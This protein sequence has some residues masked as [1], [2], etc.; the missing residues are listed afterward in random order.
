MD[1]IKKPQVTGAEKDLEKAGMDGLIN[2]L[3]RNEDPHI[4]RY[5]AYLLGKS[6]DA[7][8]VP[9]LIAALSDREKGVREQA[10]LALSELGRSAIEPLKKAMN[11]PKWETRYRAVEALG[12]IAD[13]Q[14][15]SPLINALKDERDH[16]RYMAAKGLRDMQD[17]QAIDPLIALLKDEN[18][19]VRMMAA[20]GLG[21]LGGNKVRAELEQALRS[22]QNDRVKAAIAEAMK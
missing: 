9:V 11:D 3:Q 8:T 6:G 10:A 13:Q 16:V 22:E 2:A 4:R 19:F 15:I 20:K 14:V 17:S 5:A 1:E 7:R 18:E 12:K 21:A